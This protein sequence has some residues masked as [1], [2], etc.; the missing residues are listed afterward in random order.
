MGTKPV[1]DS[2]ENEAD[3]S[4]AAAADELVSRVG[5]TLTVTSPT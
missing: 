3:E 1:T 4:L 5:E 2:P